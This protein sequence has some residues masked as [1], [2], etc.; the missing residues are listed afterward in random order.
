MEVPMQALDTDLLLT[1]TLSALLLLAGLASVLSLPWTGEELTS[2]S[3][4]LSR[5]W[6]SAR[7]L[8][9]QPFGVLPALQPAPV[10]VRT[11]RMDRTDH[12]A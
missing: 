6:Q 11:A 5:A 4:A 2:T 1:A 12:F 10:R 7:S 3:S 9:T 8:V